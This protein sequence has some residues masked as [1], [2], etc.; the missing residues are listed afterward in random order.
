MAT[1]HATRYATSDRLTF[2]ERLTALTMEFV[3]FAMVNRSTHYVE[4][5]APG[6]PALTA[7]ELVERASLW[8][9]LEDWS[10]SHAMPL[11][12]NTVAVGDI[13]AG[14]PG[15]PLPADVER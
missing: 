9:Y 2:V 15:R 8:F 14:E 4:A 3:G 11:M 10:T 12:P 6:R 7:M 5:L 13:M 1:T